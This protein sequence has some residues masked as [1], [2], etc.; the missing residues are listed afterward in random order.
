MLA[1]LG[2]GR[3]A[4]NAADIRGE[5]EQLIAEADGLMAMTRHFEVDY[6]RPV[7]LGAVLVA[8][9]ALPA[10]IVWLYYLFALSLVRR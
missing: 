3:S 5:V 10:V 8:L 4:W 2:A 1:R 7:P 9:G 6:L